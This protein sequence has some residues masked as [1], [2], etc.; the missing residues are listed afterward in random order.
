MAHFMAT[1]QGNRGKASRLGSKSSGATAAVQGWTAGVHAEAH[2]GDSANAT[3]YFE[4]FMTTGSDVPRGQWFL[5][6]VLMT[7][8][9]PR[10]DPGVAPVPRYTPA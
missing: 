3:D 8:E 9:G 2:V 4:V 6:R 10:W 1:V 7:P 5:G